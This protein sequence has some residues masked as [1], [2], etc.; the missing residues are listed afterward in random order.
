MLADWLKSSS[1]VLLEQRYNTKTNT[2]PQG[3]GAV[4]FLLFN[5]YKRVYGLIL[6][7]NGFHLFKESMIVKPM[8]FSLTVFVCVLT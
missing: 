8:F 1:S 4:I 2:T 6:Y 3:E 7:L 5:I